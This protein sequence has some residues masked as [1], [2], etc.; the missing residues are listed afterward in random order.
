MRDKHYPA[1]TPAPTPTPTPAP[2][3]TPA[4]A[5]TPVSNYARL[6]QRCFQ[7]Q[8]AVSEKE[9]TVSLYSGSNRPNFRKSAW[10]TLGQKGE[11]VGEVNTIRLDRFLEREEMDEV[12]IDMLK[13]DTEGHD[14]KV[15]Y[16]AEDALKKHQIKLIVFEFGANWGENGATLKAA[17]EYLHG[18]GYDSYMMSQY[19]CAGDQGCHHIKLGDIYWYVHGCASARVGCCRICDLLSASA[20]HMRCSASS[21]HAAHIHR[22]SLHSLTPLTHL[23]FLT[24]SRESVYEQPPLANIMSVVKEYDSRMLD[25]LMGKNQFPKGADELFEKEIAPLWKPAEASCLEKGLPEIAPA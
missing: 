11:A 14:L 15:I 18:M 20:T 2:A 16:S 19:D 23:P 17:V 1:P 7:H 8:N 25:V 24:A 22:H 6:L 12:V 10:I 3:L 21:S 5:P 13:I 9:E 4:P